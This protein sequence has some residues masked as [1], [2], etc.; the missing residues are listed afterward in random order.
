MLGEILDAVRRESPLVHCINNYVTAND[1]ANLL[2]AAGASP[3]MAQAPEEA[4]EITSAC[5]GLVLNLGTPSPEKAE[6]MLRSGRTANKMGIPVVF[7]PVGVGCSQ[8]RIRTAQ[9]LLQSVKLTVIRGNA[10]E[11]RALADGSRIRTGVDTENVLP[12]DA[13]E[14]A[15]ALARITGAV[16]VL[17]GETDIVT[18]G[19]TVCRISNGHPMM[20]HVTGCGCM[21]SALTGAYAAASP[22]SPLQAALAAVCAMG[23]CGELAHKRLTAL[24]GNASYRNYLIDAMYHL[25]GEKLEEMANYA[26]F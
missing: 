6:A 5:G 26:L 16:I 19:E 11:I 22:D 14:L 3:I 8:L 20:R 15:R 1:C 7:D 2:L 25:R 13:S 24:D 4:E 17:S 23:L 12:E 21:L 9:A 10:G 18:D